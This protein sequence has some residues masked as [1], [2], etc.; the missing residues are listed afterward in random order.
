MLWVL[1]AE[2]LK[3]TCRAQPLFLPRQGWSRGWG[4]L[5]GPRQDRG[6]GAGSGGSPIGWGAEF[7]ITS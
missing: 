5:I 7:R 6:W 2:E 3:R 1:A 4:V